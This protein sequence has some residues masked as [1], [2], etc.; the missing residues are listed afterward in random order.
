MHDIEDML[1][2]VVQ[3]KL[4]NLDEN[5]IVDLAMPLWMFTA[6]LIIKKR[7]EDAQLGVESYQK[8]LNITNSQKDF[9]RISTKELYTPSF[10]PQRV[11][12]E[13]L[14]KQKR[15]MRGDELYKFLE[16]TLKQIIRNLKRL[17]GARKLELDHRLMQRIV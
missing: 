4:F 2:L 3:H 1:L 6:S 14:S 15:M 13:D 12:Y 11:V 9:L 16:G 5:I 8:K 7:V 17:V 10:N